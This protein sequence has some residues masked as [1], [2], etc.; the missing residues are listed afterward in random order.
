MS[1][2]KSAPVECAVCHMDDDQEHWV[3]SWCAVRMCRFCRGDFG[4]RGAAALIERVRKAELGNVPG[5]SPES[6]TERLSGGGASL[7]GR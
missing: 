6:S 7:R 5:A 3:C 2:N 1:K 4:N